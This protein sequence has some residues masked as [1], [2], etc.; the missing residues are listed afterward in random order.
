MK[1]AITLTGNI[2]ESIPFSPWNLYFSSLNPVPIEELN[3]NLRKLIAA[4]NS[5]GSQY[6][7]LERAEKFFKELEENMTKLKD[8]INETNLSKR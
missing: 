6:Q 5:R 2:D 3:V 4:T 8:I 7:S 1:R